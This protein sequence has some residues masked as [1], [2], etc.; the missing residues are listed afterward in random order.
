M[1]DTLVQD[2][3]FPIIAGAI[4]RLCRRPEH[5]VPRS[6]IVRL[7]LEELPSRRLIERAYQ[8]T[9]RKKSIEK[10][11]G[12]L[13]DWF[14]QRWT[15]GD[16]KWTLLFI[17]FERSEKKIDGCWA[18]R[19]VD[20]TA[21]VVFPDEVE[22]GCEKLPEGAVHE[23]LVNAYERNP[24]AR[25]KCIEKYGAKCFVCGFSFGT[26]YGRL[27]DGLIHVHHL[28]PLSDVRKKYKVDPVADLRPV[29]PNC[30]AVIHHRRGLPYSIEEVQSFLGI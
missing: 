19:P 3:A 20:A 26:T 8:K 10:Y 15:V 2:I 27:V 1:T 17:K 18:Y 22:E 6:E 9:K 25:Q 23:S 5:F 21:I 12:N 11:A 29:C 7:L 4:E 14:S 28:V 30:H 16:Q 24:L 13:I